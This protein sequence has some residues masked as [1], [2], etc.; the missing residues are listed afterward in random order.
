M[1]KGSVFSMSSPEA[2]QTVLVASNK[3]ACWPENQVDQL[4]TAAAEAFYMAQAANA[5]H[6]G[7]ACE[8]ILGAYASVGDA[9]SAC[10]EW[11]FKL[12][13]PGIP[14]IPALPGLSMHF[15]QSA[16]CST[17]FGLGA[18]Q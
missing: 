1:S 12:G 3:Q 16:D 5:P 18:G 13:L 15:G 6:V 8:G 2:H 9:A 4:T 7:Q 11:D 10:L 17:K 14:A